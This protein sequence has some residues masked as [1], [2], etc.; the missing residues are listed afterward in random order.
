[1]KGKTVKVNSLSLAKAAT[2]FWTK[3]EFDLHPLMQ[4]KTL[5]ETIVKISHSIAKL[6]GMTKVPEKS[7]ATEL[8]TEF[9]K[10]DKALEKV[11]VKVNDLQASLDKIEKTLQEKLE[12]KFNILRKTDPKD[13]TDAENRNKVETNMKLIKN[14]V[15]A[16]KKKLH[17]VQQPAEAALKQLHAIKPTLYALSIPDNLER[18]QKRAEKLSEDISELCH[19]ASEMTISDIVV[20]GVTV[21][22]KDATQAK[23]FLPKLHTEIE[24]SGKL[25]QQAS[26]HLRRVFPDASATASTSA[27]SDVGKMQGGIA[28]LNSAM[29]AGASGKEEGKTNRMTA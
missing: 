15:E 1:M 5:A 27:S 29:G 10:T 18:C 16:A 3:I 6:E 9:Q 13:T 14:L 7:N 22:L 21:L 17:E 2:Q 23:F 4:D 20:A 28:D 25:L 11:K 12:S 8:A 26:A 24:K 19:A